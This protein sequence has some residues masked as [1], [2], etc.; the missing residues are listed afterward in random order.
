MPL[1]SSLNTAAVKFADR[2]IM[3]LA[4]DDFTVRHH[5]SPIRDHFMLKPL[6]PGDPLSAFKKIDAEGKVR[7]VARPPQSECWEMGRALY[8]FEQRLQHAST[9][10]GKGLASMIDWWAP[11][12]LRCDSLELRE[13]FADVLARAYAWR[14]LNGFGETKTETQNPVA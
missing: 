4:A 5:D 11:R 13:R 12:F 10:R 6:R 14:H 9:A 8:I 2:E 1:R 7:I 3:V